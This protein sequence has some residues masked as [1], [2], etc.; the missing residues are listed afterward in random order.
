MN[1]EL[2]IIIIVASSGMLGSEEEGDV[3]R[4]R[5]KVVSPDLGG[6][7]FTRCEAQLGRTQGALAVKSCKKR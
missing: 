4:V 7:P 1:S 6:A 2:S 3:V 5:A